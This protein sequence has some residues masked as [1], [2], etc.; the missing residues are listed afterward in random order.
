MIDPRD[1]E[2]RVH[3]G[4]CL[5][6]MRQLPD[7]CVDAVVTDPPY[8]FAA[9]PTDRVPPVATYE[10]FFRVANLTAFF[11]YPELLVGLC[12]RLGRNPNEW[13]TW[14]PVNKQMARGSGLPKSSEAIAIFGDTQDSRPLMRRRSASSIGKAIT[15]SRGLNPDECRENDVWCDASPG[16]GFLY[17][18]RL[19]PNEKPESLMAKL[20]LLCS[21]PGDLVLD[22]FL[23]SGTTG[24]VC[25]RLGTRWIG[26]EINPVYAAMAEKRIQRERDKLQLPLGATR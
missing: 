12:A 13:V 2:G 8:G 26:C 18:D 15:R 6:F 22:P 25:E 24:V 10:E 16:M 4:D 14:F 5:E 11:G 21:A 3:V 23:G 9:Y 20:I 1:W 17:A 19:H 7:G